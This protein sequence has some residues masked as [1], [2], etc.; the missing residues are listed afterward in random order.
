M[1][2]AIIFRPDGF[3]V[4]HN[5]QYE[6]LKPGK[7]F[8]N[9][10]LPVE[11]EGEP[12]LWDLLHSIDVMDKDEV[13]ILGRM[14]R[15]NVFDFFSELEKEPLETPFE[16]HHVLLRRVGNDNEFVAIGDPHETGD[17]YA[18]ELYPINIL[19]E[20]VFKLED[21]GRPFTLLEM[22]T[23]VLWFIGWYDSPNKRTAAHEDLL[24]KSKERDAE[25]EPQKETIQ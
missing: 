4:R 18:I 16:L 12:L 25:D 21:G 8:E 23:T 22:L 24:A 15:M 14:A 1:R 6:E 10:L 13:R 11:M 9:A 20:L 3:H 7:F 17:A 19:R 2:D 5:D